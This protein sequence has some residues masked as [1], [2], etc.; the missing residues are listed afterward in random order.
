MNCKFI[1]TL[2]ILLINSSVSHCQEWSQIE[3]PSGKITNIESAP[4]GIFAGEYDDRLWL[5]PYNGVYMSQDYGVTWQK[6]GL[7]GKGVKHLKYKE[8]T[9]FATAFYTT[10]TPRGLY[11]SQYP[12]TEWNNIGPNFEITTIDRCDSYM[13]IGTKLNG[14]LT[15]SDAGQNWEQ[16]IG[17]GYE[18]PEIL[19]VYCKNE[20]ILAS[21][22]TNT[23]VS[24]D[25]GSTWTSPIEFSGLTVYSI[26]GEEN[27][28]AATG[29][30][31]EGLLLSEDLGHSWKRIPITGITKSLVTVLSGQYVFTSTGPNILKTLNPHTGFENTMLSVSNS[32]DIIDIAFLDTGIQNILALNSLGKIYYSAQPHRLA[33]ATLS[34]PWAYKKETELIE[35]INSYFDHQ[36]PLLGYS[37]F[38]EPGKDSITTLKYDGKAGKSPEVFYSSHSGIDFGMEYGA[39]VLAAADGVASYYWCKECG[40]T[41]KITHPFGLQTIYMHL[42][43]YPIVTGNETAKVT[44]G[45]FIGKVGLTGRTT[46]PHLHFE[47]LSDTDGNGQFSDNFPGGRTDPFG[48]PYF[49]YQDP[50]SKFSWTDILGEHHGTISKN[51]WKT[52]SSKNTIQLV[53]GNT[54][55]TGNKIVEVLDDLSHN[56]LKIALSTSPKPLSSPLIN[57]AKY[58]YG[59]SFALETIDQLGKIS[60]YNALLKIGIQLESEYVQNIV[61]ETIKLYRFVEEASSWIEIMSTFSPETLIL[62]AVVDHLSLFA[63]FG[64]TESTTYLETTINIFPEPVDGMSPTPVNISFSG[65]G[66]K[67][68]YSVDGGITWDEYLSNVDI[69]VTGIYDL[70]YKSL[71]AQGNW[72]DTKEY[73]LKVG[74]QEDFKKITIKDAF[75]NI[76]ADNP[77]P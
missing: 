71:D 39:E 18:G 64:E 65:N 6:V 59:T 11:Q 4:E 53:E 47:V 70:L 17:N 13:Y 21:T 66:I 5:K 40:N 55:K 29:I 74:K 15:S 3:A 69:T 19:S 38:N 75:F 10:S 14:L 50:W 49:L 34:I 76:L 54:I 58:I 26:S 41:V 60:T 7:E 22:R 28:L 52:E 9:L 33:Q 36:Y 43:N 30:G 25:R 73:V 27:T 45:E 46:G 51:L 1:F 77:S 23:F 2:G 62:E 31:Y 48:W 16:K 44:A 67:T 20:T 61:P 24:F 8:G 68:F 56:F 12:Y 57:N 42:Q 32:L 37:H 35:N 72:E 63:A